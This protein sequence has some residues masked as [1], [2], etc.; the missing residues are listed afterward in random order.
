MPDS[1]D[2]KLE[3]LTK[4]IFSA[5]SW[6]RSLG[7]ILFLGIILDIACIVRG[8]EIQ[9]FGMFGYVIPGVIAFLITKPLVELSG[10]V[11]TWNR[12]ALLAMACT[13]FCIIISL[14]PGFLFFEGSLW[15]LYAVSLGFIFAIR[16]LVLV[17]IA[18]YRISH[19]L[20]PAIIQSGACMVAGFFFFGQVFLLFAGSL[21]LLFGAGVILFLW[22]VERPLK[23]NF[24]I[25]ALN[26]INAFIAHNTDGSKA[27]EEYFREIGG[28]VY[29]PQVTLFFRREGEGKQKGEHE[30]TDEVKNDPKNEVIFTVPNVH[31][32]PM[33]EIGGG[34]LPRVLHDSLGKDTFVP[35]G[36][37]THDFN[38]VSESEVEKIVSVV[39]DSR[40]DLRFGQTA[41]RSRRYSYGSVQILAQRFG[42]SILMVSTRAPEKT[43]DLDYTIGLAIMSE[44]HSR[45]ENVAFVDGH[46]AMVDVTGPV[47][48]ASYIALEYMRACE[49]ATEGE[50]G[51]R[52]EYKGECRDEREHEGEGEGEGERGP[53]RA[54]ECGSGGEEYPFSV[55]ASHVA[56]PFTR[57]QGFGDLG[58][59]ALVVC[60]DGQNTAYVLF[61]GNNM[62]AGV[63]EQIRERLLAAEFVDKDV[64]DV[65]M[66]VDVDTDVD[67]G[68]D[69]NTDAAV[70]AGL[71]VDECEVMTTDSH[72]VN[73]LSGR[74]PIGYRVSFEELYPYVEEA[75]NSAL[76][77]CSPAEVGGTTAWCEGI[78]VFGSQS[79][80]QLASTVNAMLVFI[81]PLGVAITMLAFIF[82]IVAY[83]IVV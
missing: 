17:A 27:L 46:N 8:H 55:G 53:E 20:V 39:R 36:C 26:F 80:S 57:E 42:D 33:G 24:N 81:A 30:Q 31:P 12:S 61:D 35:H 11:I 2:A 7:I 41:G 59:Q 44:G 32:G 56:V 15:I 64:D 65:D 75:V 28:E 19:M 50:S 69:V 38:L 10:K 68:V 48:P 66:D 16:L 82:S 5:P 9:Y 83:M 29:V 23:R 77:D 22:L 51:C 72:V 21:H 6:R 45:F 79:I 71:Q 74:N 78:V 70:H 43:E 52:D 4:Y 49:M 25:S 13:V 14:F 18:D 67:G 76:D 73:T 40:E 54:D 62:E 37:A 34:N 3:G 63:R 58:I 60:A 1:G 47:M